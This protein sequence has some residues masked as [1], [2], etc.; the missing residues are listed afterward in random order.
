M[1]SNNYSVL[2]FIPIVREGL[3]RVHTR[4]LSVIA[5]VNVSLNYLLGE[6]LSYGLLGRLY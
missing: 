3:S 2:T 4:M 5:P 6:V 1:F